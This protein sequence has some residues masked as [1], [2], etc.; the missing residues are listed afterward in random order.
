MHMP[1]G[2]L[3]DHLHSGLSS[4]N[5]SL[6][7]KISMRAAKGLEY[8]HKE[9]EPPIAYHNVKTSNF[10]L[11]SAWGARIADFGLL[12]AN[13]KDLGGDMKRCIQFWNCTARDS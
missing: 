8:L 7:L 2:T 5:W 12:S 6:R 3:H 11:D 10:L 9:A 1:H 4:L 13:E